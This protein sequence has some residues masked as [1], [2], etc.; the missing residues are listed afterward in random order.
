LP[1]PLN[2]LLPDPKVLAVPST[3]VFCVSRLPTL[4]NSNQPSSNYIPSPSSPLL[5]SPVLS[6]PPLTARRTAIFC[7]PLALNGD[8]TDHKRVVYGK[9]PAR[10]VGISAEQDAHAARPC[11]LSWTPAAL[12]YCW[13]PPPAP[14]STTH[15]D[16]F[17][18]HRSRTITNPRL[19][20]SLSLSV[21]PC[22]LSIRHSAI[23]LSDPRDYPKRPS[24][25]DGALQQQ[26]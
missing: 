12:F 14:S 25:P 16:T 3:C 10:G 8:A 6:C 19:A 26:Y 23:S 9:S 20:H 11:F 4:L 2:L 1:P 13:A 5:S 17:S 24:D 15:P 22:C 21:R 18:N 7:L